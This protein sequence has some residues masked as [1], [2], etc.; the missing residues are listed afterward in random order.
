MFTLAWVINVMS[1]CFF[2]AELFKLRR[3]WLARSK[4]DS[5]SLEGEVFHFIGNFLA[6]VVAVYTCA[7]F[8]VAFETFLASCCLIALIWKVKWLIKKKR[9]EKENEELS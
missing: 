9:K 2:C 3:K 6:V 8:A 5:T 7:F 4:M 1:F